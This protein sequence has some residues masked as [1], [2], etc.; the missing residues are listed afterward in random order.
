MAES[1][2]CPGLKR[3]REARSIADL[4]LSSPAE[5]LDKPMLR[6]RRPD[7]T[8][9]TWTR[10]RTA[11]AVLRLAAWLE[12]Q[13]VRPGDR[14]GI[15][16]HNAPEWFIADFAV[17]RLGA[18]SVPAYFTDPAEAVRAVFE[19]AGVRLAVVEPGEQMAKLEGSDAQAL[20]FR[21]GDGASVASIIADESWDDRLAAPMPQRDDLAT[22]IYTSGTTG[23]PKGVMLTHDNILSDVA[24]GLGGVP[25]WPEDVF[26][27]FLPVSHAFERT[28]G[29]FLPT[30]CGAEIAYAEAVTT[31]MRDLPEVRPTIVL[32]VPRLY[33]KIHA[34]VQAKLAESSA[35]ARMV[36]RAAQSLGAE[37]FG[38]RQ[39]GRDLH[40]I[41]RWIWKRLDALAHAPLR[42]KLGGRLRA[43]ISGG[44]ALHPE[45]ARFLLAA[46]ITILPGYGLTE[47]SPVLTVN[48]EE[49]IKPETV[50]PALPGVEL[51]LAEDGELLARGAM[52][53]QGYWNRP[54]ETEATIDADG[55]LH[56]GDIAGIDEDGFVRIIDRKKEIMVLSNGENVPPAVVEQ[57]LL[58]DPC[59]LQAMIIAEKRPFVAALVVPDEAALAKAWRREKGRPLPPDWREDAAVHDWMLARMRAD[60]R[61]LASYMQVRRFAFV[62]EEWTQAN[63]LVTPT[64]KVKRRAILER[65]AELIASLYAA[66][67]EE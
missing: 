23:H 7:G 36:F 4:L 58:R 47:A 64:L 25:V 19:D 29:H 32:S 10:V 26:L 63:G 3:A 14:V 52:V 35:V 40:G 30:A 28:V 38:L 39:Q 18:V 21:G 49:R 60:E 17:L 59:I 27:S 11:Q 46:D 50:G 62:D 31:L 54:E 33:E 51:R 9:K 67:D 61:D 12:A 41:R 22:L 53:M 2:E 15:L 13:G 43:F 55:W 8:W 37:R 45:I 57:H 34:G 42:A 16:G 24:A 1:R 66:G 6:F 56:T 44:A 65:Y 48:R 20:P 5:W